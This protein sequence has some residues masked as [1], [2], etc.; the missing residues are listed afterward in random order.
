MVKLPLEGVL[1]IDFSTIIAAPLIGTLLADFGAEVIKV[2]LPKIGDTTRGGGRF[3]GLRSLFWLTM[4]RNKKSITLDLHKKKGQDLAR[5]LCSKA[6]IVLFNFRPGV[7]EKWNLGPEVLQ[8]IN[9][10]LIIGLVSGYGQT[11]PY[12]HK[13][14]YDRT[15]S[16]FSGL[17]YTSGYPEHPPVRSGFPLID[18]LTGYLGAFAVMAALYNRDVNKSG[19]EVI[20]L[21]LTE[22]AFKTSGGALSIYSKTGEIYERSGNRI[23]FV[24]PAEN[25][26]TKDG[27]N[28]AIN[29]NSVKQWE[30]LAGA[31][32]RS[33]LLKYKKFNSALNRFQNQDELYE[34]IG[35]WV[36][37]YSA[38]EIMEILEEVGVP[39][40]KVNNIADLAEHPHMLQ[41]EAIIEYDDY[42]FGKILVP[43][44]VP[45]LKNFPGQIR[46]LGTK[47]GEYNQEIYKE[48]LGLTSE[49]IKDLEEKGVL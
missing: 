7:L 47:L 23:P 36:K 13:G 10:D 41:R 32:G 15:V 5:K 12:K 16:A 11:G 45:K 31:M 3:P 44:I 20:D 2:E 8:K 24:V 40:E 4:N 28:V 18:Y 39:C 14:G 27:R 35:E 49:E 48:I 37:N 33:D 42:E 9:P 29:A 38:R 46:F 21:S 26:E 43:G 19:G 17:T 30:I 22:A 25:F 6:D 1:V 34:I